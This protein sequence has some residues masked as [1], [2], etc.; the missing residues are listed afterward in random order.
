MRFLICTEVPLGNAN[1]KVAVKK[2]R[3]DGLTPNERGIP[4]HLSLSLSPYFAFGT[5]VYVVLAGRNL[6]VKSLAFHRL[7]LQIS[8]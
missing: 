3:K 1:K 4:L 7:R 6:Y 8:S 5:Y 2:G